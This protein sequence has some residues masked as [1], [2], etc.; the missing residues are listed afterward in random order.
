MIYLISYKVVKLL[1]KVGKIYLVKVQSSQLY[2]DGQKKTVKKSEKLRVS[3][4]N[5]FL[6]SQ[7]SQVREAFTQDSPLRGH[8]HQLS[9]KNQG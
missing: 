1:I 2:K 4:L 7:K 8:F 3:N 5:I 6:E 9:M